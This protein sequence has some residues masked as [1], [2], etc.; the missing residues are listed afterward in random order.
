MKLANTIRGEMELVINGK[1]VDGV[2]N[3]NALRLI[4]KNEK[5]DLDSFE[6]FISE[7]PLDSAPKIAYYSVVNKHILDGKKAKLPEMEQF[8]AHFFVDE[9]NFERTIEAFQGAM[10]VGKGDKSKNEEG[11]T[12]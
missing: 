6:K 8:I 1:P 2:F 4:L 7:N 11:A 9:S 3:N 5:V 10:G 12:T